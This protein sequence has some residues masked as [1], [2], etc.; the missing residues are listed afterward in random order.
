M[1]DQTELEQQLDSFDAEER[2]AAVRELCREGDL[3]KAGT[4]AN[5][6]MHS[7]FSFNAEDWSPAHIAW[8]ARKAGLYA[9]G[10]CDFDVLDGADEFLEAG[11]ALGLRTSVYVETR[12]F[13]AE[14]AQ[15]EIT[16]PGE[17][18][19]T[20]IMGAGFGGSPEDGSPQ[21]GGL[22]GYRDRARDRNVA[23][24]DRIN[25]H[26]R[27]CTIDYENDVLPLTPAGAATERHIV[28]A[29]VHKARDIF[30]HADYV[31]AFW[32]GIMD[33][34]VDET[35]ELL[36]D[37]PR[38][39]EVVRARLVKRGGLGYEQPSSDTFPP[40]QEFIDWVLACEAIPM[41][42]WLD[43]TSEGEA[44]A[45]ALLDC[46]VAKGCAA[47]NIIPDRNWNIADTDEKAI[48]V[49]NL[50]AIVAEAEAR[51]LPINVGT[52]MNKLGLPFVDDFE[53]E[54]LWPHK[55]AFIR[56]ARIMVAQSLLGR[57]AHFSYTGKRATAEL[58]DAGERNAFFEHVGA[59]PPLDEEQAQR[60]E[61]MG[62]E[63]A[64]RWFRDSAM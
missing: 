40:L 23:V 30:E 45:G 52:E 7:F 21:A 6:H 62:P 61:D 43:G 32:A 27:E 29:Y 28:R 44:D 58:P 14:Y 11:L 59:M 17:P 35:V 51:N 39:E 56:G 47:V 26:L 31:A 57:Y 34:D 19:V 8:E 2:M 41:I 60:L 33:G 46:Q 18:G 5:M 25:P 3:P 53:G 20:Y 22:A 49:A 13:L 9:A 16:S 24:I 4:N 63:R 15:A 64:L 38:F 10:L 12:A 37:P 48:K 54:A 50:N 55:E 1:T 36:V 42:T